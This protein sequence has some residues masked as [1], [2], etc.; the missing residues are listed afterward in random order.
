MMEKAVN[1]FQLD[2]LTVPY[3]IFIMGFLKMYI[4]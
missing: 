3:Y 4:A 1:Q 2:T